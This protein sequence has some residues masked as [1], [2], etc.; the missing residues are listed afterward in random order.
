MSFPS[1]RKKF[2]FIVLIILAS[3]IIL[4]SGLYLITV[5]N[6]KIKKPDVE[7]GLYLHSAVEGLEYDHVPGSSGSLAGVTVH[8]NSHGFRGEE[9]KPSQGDSD[10]LAAVIGDSIVFGQGVPENGTLPVHIEHILEAETGPVSVEVLNAGVR[11]YDMDEYLIYLKERVLPLGPDF[12]VLVITEIND[13]RLEPSRLS[14]DKIEKWSKSWWFELPFVKPLMA[15]AYAEEVNRVFVEYVGEIYDPNGPH[16]PVFVGRLKTFQNICKDNDIGL[17]VITF[18]MISEENM[19]KKE[20][21]QLQNTLDEMGIKWVDPMPELSMHKADEL[22]VS[23]DDFHPN[24]KALRIAAE[25]A[26]APLSR[27]IME[28]ID[29]EASSKREDP[30]N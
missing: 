4:V 27:M 19:F 24:G 9:L 1:N 12:V 6:D 5:K 7:T 30:G 3:A 23:R 14:S 13:T 28:K 20:R 15:G 10:I 18:P 25:M 29:S 17:L 22:V 21:K 16:W 8:I 11:G 26:A 2:L